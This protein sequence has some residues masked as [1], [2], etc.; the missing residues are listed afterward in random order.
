MANGSQRSGAS[1]YLA[2]IVEE[3]VALLLSSLLD[4]WNETCSSVDFPYFT[5]CVA[6]Q[7]QMT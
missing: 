2:F 5:S 6:C 4:S 1:A 3:V 7:H